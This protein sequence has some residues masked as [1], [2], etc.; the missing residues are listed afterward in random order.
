MKVDEFETPSKAVLKKISYWKG[1]I[2]LRLLLTVTHAE[3]CALGLE[4]ILFIDSECL[5]MW[6]LKVICQSVIKGST[7]HSPIPPTRIITT[8]KGALRATKNPAAPILVQ[9]FSS[10]SSSWWPWLC[11]RSISA[12]LYTGKYWNVVF[13]SIVWS[14]L[15][16]L[17]IETEAGLLISL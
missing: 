6:K 14:L 7:W 13:I 2:W 16:N 10:T 12:W 17:K 5:Q 1:G 8:D 9:V 4:C 15:L 3:T 11:V